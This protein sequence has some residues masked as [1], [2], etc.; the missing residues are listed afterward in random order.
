MTDQTSLERRRQ[1]IQDHLLPRAVARIGREAIAAHVQLPKLR[2]LADSLE[3]IEADLLVLSKET[4]PSPEE[5]SQYHV[6]R[7]QRRLGYKE[8]GQGVLLQMPSEALP[9]SF[10]EAVRAHRKIERELD[11]IE[12][13]LRSSGG[14]RTKKRRPT[15]RASNR[16]IPDPTAPLDDLVDA[17]PF[18]ELSQSSSH[19]PMPFE[20]QD[21]PDFGEPLDIPRTTDTTP[22]YKRAMYRIS[23]TWDTVQPYN[24]RITL[25]LLLCLVAIFGYQGVR[26]TL[27]QW[28]QRNKSAEYTE[29]T[30][31]SQGDEIGDT[32]SA[33]TGPSVLDT[34][35]GGVRGLR[36]VGLALLTVSIAAYWKLGRHKMNRL[37]DVGLR[38]LSAWGPDFG[39]A[40]QDAESPETGRTLR[41]YD[42]TD[43][44]KR[45]RANWKRPVGIVTRPSS[46]DE[47]SLDVQQSNWTVIVRW[48]LPAVILLNAIIFIFYRPNPEPKIA[49]VGEAIVTQDVE[50]QDEE[51]K[52]IDVPRAPDEPVSESG[53]IE[54]RPSST[55]EQLRTREVQ[56]HLAYP[57]QTAPSEPGRIAVYVLDAPTSLLFFDS[58]SGQ[59]RPIDGIATL[60]AIGAGRFHFAAPKSEGLLEMVA[61]NAGDLRAY[62]LLTTV[63]LC[64]DFT[65]A[66]RGL[67]NLEC[68]A[69]FRAESSETSDTAASPLIARRGAIT[70][71]VELVRWLGVATERQLWSSDLQMRFGIDSPVDWW[72]DAGV[73]TDATGTITHVLIRTGLASLRADSTVP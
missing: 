9:N 67:G 34:A 24:G 32:A 68:V 4:A 17:G 20:I 72:D 71:S 23:D 43:P 62:G 18:P 41:V 36:L 56:V 38:T 22:L 61:A 58:A 65:R 10:E 12:S 69:V 2:A 13:E 31:D 70:T 11:D 55:G 53:V 66:P 52:G 6:L 46:D 37:R 28:E 73:A 50:S 57:G 54:Q 26:S 15:K 64:T 14:K 27:D 59:A 60:Y 29:R 35:T 16:P 42:P 3:S 30:D 44:P 51:P 21:P 5:I 63:R 7:R 25:S 48:S 49:A 39:D 8:F 45:K 40:A 1:Q 47:P 33:K 19:T